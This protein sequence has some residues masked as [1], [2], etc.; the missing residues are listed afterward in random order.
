MN[1]YLS[2]ISGNLLYV[3]NYFPANPEFLIKGTTTKTSK[4]NGMETAQYTYSSFGNI[5][6]LKY[7]TK[8]HSK[9]D[10]IINFN[11]KYDENTD[12][13]KKILSNGKLLFNIT[14]SDDQE[15]IPQLIYFKSYKTKV[16]MNLKQT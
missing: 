1:Y 5:T 7:E 10:T 14:Y 9:R 15:N 4:E 2:D 8:G 12:R 16:H 3:D 13:I 6:H 11:F